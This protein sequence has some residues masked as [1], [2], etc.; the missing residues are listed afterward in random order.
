MLVY[1]TGYG[2]HGFTYDPSVG[3]FILTHENMKFPKLSK[4]YSVNG[5]N[6]HLNFVVISF[7]IQFF[8]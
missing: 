5:N 4:C 6:I 8:S 1:S 3:E 2:V 7:L